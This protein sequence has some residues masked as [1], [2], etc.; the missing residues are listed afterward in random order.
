[1]VLIYVK[2]DARE[3]GVAS[4]DAVVDGS[5]VVEEEAQVPQFQALHITHLS[6]FDLE[7]SPPIGRTGVVDPSLHCH[8]ASGR[9]FLFL[10]HALAILD[11]PCLCPVQPSGPAFGSAK[12]CL[13]FWLAKTRFWP[14][15]LHV[16]LSATRYPDSSHV[17]YHKSS[18]PPVKNLPNC[19]EPGGKPTSV[20]IKYVRRTLLL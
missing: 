16:G 12:R 14:V 5:D 2:L 18:F 9:G 6:T 13:N 20:D 17:E 3:V 15:R 1:M 7:A 19:H 10:T 8:H 11:P 4:A